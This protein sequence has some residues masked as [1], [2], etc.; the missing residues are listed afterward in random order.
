MT[1]ITE[2]SDNKEYSDKLC[3]HNHSVE[4]EDGPRSV[5]YKK[6]GVCCACQCMWGAKSR[7]KNKEHYKNDPG[8]Q[9]YVRAYNR[10]H[11]RKY[12]AEHLEEIQEYQRNYH[13]KRR[14]AIQEARR[15]SK[16]LDTFD[17]KE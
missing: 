16:I 2:L 1:K 5:R 8:H 17:K 10:E 13:H 9:E 11:A 6:T 3:N 4:T 14:L 12:R 7:K 15:L